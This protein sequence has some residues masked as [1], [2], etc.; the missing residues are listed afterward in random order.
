MN[1]TDEQIKMLKEC[2]E[3]FFSVSEC[4]LVLGVSGKELKV[5]VKSDSVIKAA[6]WSGFL[7]K[8]KSIQESAVLLAERGSAQAQQHCAKLIMDNDI[9]VEDVDEE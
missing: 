4:A 5:A 3:A 7:S 8:K 2:A 1:L 9:D 6:Y